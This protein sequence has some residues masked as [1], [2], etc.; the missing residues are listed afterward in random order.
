MV[1]QL[2]EHG[3]DSTIR[4]NNN[5]TLLYCAV[6]I[7]SDETVNPVLELNGSSDINIFST[8]GLPPLFAACL[9]QKPSV[10]KILVNNG[11]DVNARSDTGYT[12]LHAAVSKDNKEIVSFLLNNGGDPNSEDIFFGTPYTMAVEN[13]S[14]T[15]TELL[16][17]GGDISLVGAY[18]QTPAAIFDSLG[19]WEA[20]VGKATKLPSPVSLA[21]VRVCR[22]QRLKASIKAAIRNERTNMIEILPFNI[23]C[24]LLGFLGNF[25]DSGIA[26]EQTVSWDDIGNTAKHAAR[27]NCQACY[28]ESGSLF[29]CTC[30]P[31]AMFCLGCFSHHPAFHRVLFEK[32]SAD[33]IF[34]SG[35]RDRQ[36][37]SFLDTNGF[38]DLRYE[39]FK[40]QDGNDVT[41]PDGRQD[42]IL[43]LLREKMPDGKPETLRKK[44]PYCHEEHTFI[45]VPSWE[46]PDLSPGTVNTRGQTVEEWLQEL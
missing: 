46:W 21:D 39:L 17:Y 31:R 5:E 10:V 27:R 16:D 12:A 9:R 28:T 13:M 36:W 22:I 26:F 37:G 19:R 4:G 23:I 32:L 41:T 40:R 8:I 1:K 30:C 7:G 11:A 20:E 43:T 33:D 34:A 6:G 3:A 25:R 44:F 29:I 38:M 35:R 2:F 42:R 45:C 15:R 24:H 14:E 18:G